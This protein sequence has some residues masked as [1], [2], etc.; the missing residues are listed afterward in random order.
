[1]LTI[2]LRDLEA[3]GM[4]SRHA[5][6]EVPPRVEYSLT[7]RGLSFIP[8]LNEIVNWGVDNMNDI[9]KDRQKRAGQ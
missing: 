2:T 1:M 8:L 5:Y 7:A 9:I 6:A 3:D 4:V